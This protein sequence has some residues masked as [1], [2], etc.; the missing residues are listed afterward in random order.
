MYSD[1]SPADKCSLGKSFG[2][3]PVGLILTYALSRLSIP[4]PIILID[5]NELPTEYPKMDLT[6]LRSMELLRRLGLSHVLRNHPEAVRSNERFDAGFLT[7]L[8]PD[9]NVLGEWKVDSP[10]EQQQESQRVNDGSYP[11]EPG[12]RIS[13]ILVEKLLRDVISGLQREG[14][15]RVRTVLLDHK[16]REKVVYARFLVGCD[17]GSSAVRRRSGIGMVEG[18]L[19][20]NS[21]PLRLH[22]VHFRSPY[23]SAYLDSNS[24]RYWHA[25]PASG[26]FLIDQDGRDTF[27]AH[28]PLTSPQTSDSESPNPHETIS[29]VLTGMHEPFSIPDSE[30]RILVHSTW[31]PSFALAETYSSKSKLVILAGDSA[32]RTPPHG[33]YGLNSGIADAVDLAWRLTAVVKG[34]GGP[35]LLEAYGIERRNM[36][37]RALMRSFRHMGEHIKL[38]ELYQKHW[39]DLTS[40][41]EKG[42]GVRRMINQWIRESGPDILDR[43][44]ELDTRYTFSPCISDSDTGCDESEQ[45]EDD[46][47]VK[48]YKPS[49]Q[50]GHRAPHVFLQNDKHGWSVY[51]LFGREW[52]LVHFTTNPSSPEEKKQLRN[53]NTLLKV[54]L[55]KD[56]PIKY[57]I[58]SEEEHARK[59]YGRDF[60]LVRPDTHVAWRGNAVPSLEVAEDILAVVVGWKPQSGY[61][62]PSAT[63]DKAEQEEENKFLDMIRLIAGNPAGGQGQEKNEET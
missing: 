55:K 62:R 56:F 44:I 24:K 3:G 42:E 53:N 19:T 39:D 49:T 43:G 9:G 40:G 54:A 38:A 20:D 27:T 1:L 23:L 13:Q 4:S 30:V 37:R 21:R 8:G 5:Q 36:M 18:S 10:D 26:G 52:T 57:L 16:G 59:I 28:Y 34:Y 14:D 33:G 60:V 11:A 50:P 22:L 63:R 46:W 32:H 48:R 6:N 12:L 15:G 2:A 61:Q 45:G 29:K 25:F 7:G 47:D 41:S 35:F 17:G 31:T 51:D 58:L